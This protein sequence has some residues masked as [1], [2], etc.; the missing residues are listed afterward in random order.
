LLQINFRILGWAGNA[1]K[2]QNQGGVAMGA[3]A[4]QG[5]MTR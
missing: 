5:G 4:F 3:P 2:Q 1:E